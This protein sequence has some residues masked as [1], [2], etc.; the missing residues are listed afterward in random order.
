V[1]AVEGLPQPVLD[2]R[3]D[4]LD[5]A[6]L[7]AVAEVGNVRRKAHA[8]LAP[9]DDNIGISSG[10]LLGAQRHGA[11]P[12]T[13]DLI[14]A[15]GGRVDRHAGGDR[16]L[17]GRVLTLARGQYLTHDHFIDIGCG[18]LGPIERCPNGDFAKCVS[19]HARKRAIEGADGC[20]R[21]SDDDNIFLFHS[22]HLRWVGVQC[23]NLGTPGMEA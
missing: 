4:E 7:L 5:R 1:V 22:P 16:R 18:N 2:H 6:H 23:H 13:A 11:E 17:A 10:D 14:D 12:R 15:P 21:R 20:A 3:I 19:R 8:L 9:G